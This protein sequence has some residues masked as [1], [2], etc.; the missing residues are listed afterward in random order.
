VLISQAIHS[1]DLMLTLAGPVASVAAIAGTS[2]MHRME[3]EDTVGAGMRFAN[4]ALGGL[5][6]STASFPGAG[7]QLTLTFT[8]AT[9]I[10]ADGALQVAWRDGRSAFRG[11]R[12][13][14]GLLERGASRP[15]PRLPRR[16]GGRPRSGD[17]RRSGAG[18]APPDRRPAPI[19]ERGQE[20]RAV[21]LRF[22]AIGLDH[23]HI[24]GQVGRLLELGCEC[25]GWW[26]EGGDP[27][28]L[29]GFVKR[30]PHLQRVD[31]KRRLLEDPSIALIVTAA[32]PSDR[33]DVA[34]AAM[35][36]GK[37]VMSDKPGCT[38]LAQLD[39]LRAAVAPHRRDV[40]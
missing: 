3:T 27:Q 14:D 29:E 33:A 37:D 35:E 26:A 18:R 9:A 11:R 23:R 31:D 10:L 36:H 34:I 19:R 38:S 8:E 24:Y 7:E 13:S 28:P 16:G 2:A 40:N 25:A 30:F 17:H 32:V 4:G 12:R 5:F 6:A 21:S 1:L 20:R 39:D 15:D 22:A